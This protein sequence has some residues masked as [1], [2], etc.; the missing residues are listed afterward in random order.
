MINP[1]KPNIDL[2][3]SLNMN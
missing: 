2:W 3:L 1:G